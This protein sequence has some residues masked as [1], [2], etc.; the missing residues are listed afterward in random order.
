MIS[1]LNVTLI[2]VALLLAALPLHARRGEPD[3]VVVQHIL[4]GFK[5]SVPEKKLDRTKM[6]AKALALDLLR[7]AEEGDDFDALVKEY[8]DDRYPG[9][10]IL[11][12]KNA[13]RVPQGTL[14][15]QVVARFGDIAFQLEVGEVGIANY[16]AALSP[17]GWHL[18]KRIE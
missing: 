18:I 15:S 6:Q 1:R 10:M 8:T 14:R 7:R 2:L 5:K 11:T 4:I 3:L 13:P 16:H 12:N 17:Y 9:M